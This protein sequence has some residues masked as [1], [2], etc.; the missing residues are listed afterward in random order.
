VRSISSPEEIDP[1]RGMVE[2][3]LEQELNHQLVDDF[4]ESQQS[5]VG[6]QRE[7]H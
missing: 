3:F 6:L 7:F 2:E 1:F 4:Q 5:S